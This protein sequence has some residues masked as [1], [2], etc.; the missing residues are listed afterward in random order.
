[1]SSVLPKYGIKPEMKFKCCSCEDIIWGEDILNKGLFLYVVKKNKENILN[2][3][4]RCENCE[5]DLNSFGDKS[6][7]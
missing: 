1:M 7:N 6:E 5:E 2:S 3:I 4:F